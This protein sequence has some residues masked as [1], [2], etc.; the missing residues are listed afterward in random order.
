MSELDSK[1]KPVISADEEMPPAPGEWVCWTRAEARRNPRLAQVVQEFEPLDFDAGRRA[2]E[3]L[4]EEALTND[5]STKTYVLV[6]NDRVE[7]FIAMCTCEVELIPKH[8]KEVG[9]P[10]RRR[11]PGVLLTWVAKHRDATCDGKALVEVAYGLASEVA[12]KVGAVAFAL[13]PMDEDIAK[14]WREKYSFRNTRDDRRLWTSI[15]VV[16]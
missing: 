14:V 3:F 1:S 8:S 5:G 7:G 4:K 9:V 2:A 6:S 16:D 11:L 15:E 12:E 13:D 10:H